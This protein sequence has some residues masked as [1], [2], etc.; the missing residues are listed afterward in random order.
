MPPFFLSHHHPEEFHRTYLL[1]QIRIC[2]RCL[3]TY[4][5][6]FAAV[7]VQLF[8]RAPLLAPFDPFLAVALTLPALIDWVVGRFRPHAGA[9]WLRTLTG[10][11]L[12]LA[13]GRTLFVHLFRPFHPSL[14]LQLGVV[15]AI[16]LPVILVTYRRRAG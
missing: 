13:L 4:P 10:A 3:G 14:L 7:S 1:G 5:V 12:G 15:T 6:L 2:A 8:L 11:L 16:A 9:N